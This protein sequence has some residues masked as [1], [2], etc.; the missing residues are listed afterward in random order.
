[1]LATIALRRWVRVA[2]PVGAVLFAAAMHLHWSVPGNRYYAIWGSEGATEVRAFRLAQSLIARIP[3]LRDDNRPILFWYTNGDELIDSLQSTYLWSY[4][5]LNSTDGSSPG[6][7]Q[8]TDRELQR[9][10]AGG[11]QRLVLLDRSAETVKAGLRTLAQRG[12]VLRDSR[13]EELCAEQLCVVFHA[14]TIGG[15]AGAPP[16]PGLDD[17]HRPRRER[18]LIGLEGP[19]LLAGV[20]LRGFGPMWRWQNRLSA[21][22][23][24][25]VPP[26]RLAEL[27]PEGYVRFNSETDLDH[28]VTEFVSPTDRAAGGTGDFRLRIRRDGRFLPA[29]TCRLV[30]QNDRFEAAFEMRC[31]DPDGPGNVETGEGFH[32]AEIPER[33]RLV[34]FSRGTE[35]TALPVT[36]ELLQAIAPRLRDCGTTLSGSAARPGGLHRSDP[37]C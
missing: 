37:P 18:V 6:M 9:L 16:F 28:L 29:P 23:R 33:V 14:S 10:T 19:A 26:R 12:I 36:V 5:R 17:A 11:P 32:L 21:L 8:L 35:A 7:P 1:M 24:G 30:V 4:S 15:S 27:M 13:Q 2:A 3:K 20:Q 25:I 31:R 22:S 34:F